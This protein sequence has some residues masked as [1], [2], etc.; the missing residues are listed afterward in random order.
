[1]QVVALGIQPA[2]K[3]QQVALRSPVV[4]ASDDEGYRGLHFE[5]SYKAMV[6]VTI[7]AT[8]NRS[9]ARSRPAVFTAPASPGFE[10]SSTTALAPPSTSPWANSHPSLWCVM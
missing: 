9:C 6:A 8:L 3:L 7:A 10:R 5:A 1:M 4:E 2:R